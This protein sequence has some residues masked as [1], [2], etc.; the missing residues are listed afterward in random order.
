MLEEELGVPLLK[1][2]SRSVALTA[3]GQELAAH[4][5]RVLRSLEV[6]AEDSRR[7]AR[8][9]LGR[10]TVGY[11]TTAT[12]LALPEVLVAFRSAAPEVALQL[13]EGRSANLA[14]QVELG[15]LDTAF[16]C[17][18][19]PASGLVTHVIAEDAL[20][21]AVPSDH[22]LAR[23][24]SV[25]IQALVGEPIVGSNPTVEPGWNEAFS[26]ALARAGVSLS[27]VQEADSKLALFGLVAAGVG[28]ALISAS[29]AR[30]HRE[31]VVLRPVRGAHAKLE[32]GLV[33]RV[34]EL[35]APLA[36]FVA[37]ARDASRKL[38]R[39]QV[40]SGHGARPR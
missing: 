17:L 39:G 25:D 28:V 15:E 32:L 29:A 4:A 26:V 20:A 37:T 34:G 13:S 38:K 33:H 36:R 11:T 27:V 10:I 3:A 21:V 9:E 40:R 1:R 24:S 23:R 19:V 30:I 22:P 35:D 5:R 18:P 8:G 2:T 16:V 14:R 7:A 31:G 12:Y 6:A